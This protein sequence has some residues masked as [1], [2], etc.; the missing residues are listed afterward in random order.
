MDTGYREDQDGSIKDASPTG[1]NRSPTQGAAKEK[2][3]VWIDAWIRW[4]RDSKDMV[5]DDE[6]DDEED[7]PAPTETFSFSYEVRVPRHDDALAQ[8]LHRTDDSANNNNITLELKGFPSE[9]EQIWNSTGL[10]V[11]PCSHHLCEYLVEHSRELLLHNGTSSSSILELGSGLGRV[12][13]LAYHLMYHSMT[14]KRNPDS[15]DELTNARCGRHIFLTDGDTDTLRQLRQNVSDN[16]ITIDKQQREGNNYKPP[17]ISCHQLLWGEQSAIQFC[18][19]HGIYH[20]RTDATSNGNGDPVS[21]TM[22]HT[23]TASSPTTID[24][25]LGSD[26]VYVPSVIVPLFET[27]CALLPAPSP[28]DS[29]NTHNSGTFLMAHSNRR[30]GSSVTLEMILEGAKNFNLKH[31]ILLEQNDIYVL[32]F[33]KKKLKS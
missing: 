20:S 33:Q 10:T 17:S 18:R 15:V 12:G 30:Q 25:I 16:N 24:L 27:V 23:S 1:N 28:D 3:I 29:T 2:E 22:H 11:W 26:L 7:I 6:E 4:E 5:D 32:K 8:D 31:E 9:S 21:R 19:R 14:S 13:L